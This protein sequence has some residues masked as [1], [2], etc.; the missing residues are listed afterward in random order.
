M[1]DKE[2]IQTGVKNSHGS[3]RGQPK[4]EEWAKNFN[5]LRE[6]G[7]WRV[8]TEKEP[9]LFFKKILPKPTTTFSFQPLNGL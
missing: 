3:T 1:F 4:L 8:N 5:K 7:A 9:S 2:L 6:R